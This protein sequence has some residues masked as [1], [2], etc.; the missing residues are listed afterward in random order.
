MVTD[1]A[2]GAGSLLLATLS[3]DHEELLYGY[4]TSH[5]SSLEWRG[6]WRKFS[7]TSTQA[8]SLFVSSRSLTWALDTPRQHWAAGTLLNPDCPGP[9]ARGL[10]VRAADIRRSP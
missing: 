5:E 3:P 1:C 8:F 2:I 6:N 7:G 9:R 4:A 10:G